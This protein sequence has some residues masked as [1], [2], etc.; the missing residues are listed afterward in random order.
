MFH[1]HGGS[2]FCIESI[3]AIVMIW[4]SRHGGKGDSQADCIQLTF[5]SKNDALEKLATQRYPIFDIIYSS[6]FWGVSLVTPWMG[7]FLITKVHRS[8]RHHQKWS[9]QHPTSLKPRF[10][11]LREK[12]S[13][14][15]CGIWSKIM[16]RMPPPIWSEHPFLQTPLSPPQNVANWN[17]MKNHLVWLGDQEKNPWKKTSS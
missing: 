8:H 9:V 14:Q 10:L 13:Q 3:V 2:K 7:F 6:N 11:I 17:L 15:E 1:V 16:I 4:K 5:I 12:A